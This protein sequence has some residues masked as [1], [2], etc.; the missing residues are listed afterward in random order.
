MATEEKLREYLKRVTVDLTRARR[1]LA[2]LADDRH[3][4][5]AVI[6]MAC[7]FPG[8]GTVEDF[9]ELLRDG[10]SSVVEVP[11][12]RWNIDDYYNPDRRAA[13]GVY[14]R[15]G[16]FLP[17]IAGWDADF[18]GVSPQEA[19]RMDPHQRLLMEL[20]WEGRRETLERFI[21]TGEWTPTQA[22]SPPK[23]E[24]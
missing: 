14:T 22:G 21:R 24:P 16:A 6:G 12:S 20:V 17:D 23:A 15:H 11:M 3:E 1:R 2:E 7:R 18:F 8:G 4:P 10:R 9:W 19:L 5:V 13:G